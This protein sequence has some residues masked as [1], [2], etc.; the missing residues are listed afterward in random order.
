MNNLLPDIPSYQYPSLMSPSFN[1]EPESVLAKTEPELALRVLVEQEH[2]KRLLAELASETSKFNTA[3]S[4]LSGPASIIA[5]HN[6]TRG[7]KLSHYFQRRGLF[8]GT[9]EVF[10]ARPS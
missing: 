1:I 4:A 9:E 5:Q 7:V 3:M 2:T 6:P 8:G 10:E